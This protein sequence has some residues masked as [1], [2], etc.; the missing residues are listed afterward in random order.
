MPSVSRP[1]AVAIIAVVYILTGLAGLVS[2]LSQVRL[3]Q[4]FE[5]DVL[6]AALVAL[7]AIV[8]GIFLWRGRDWA[9]WLALAWIGFHVVL[10]FFHSAGEVVAHG[11]LFAVF[12]WFL[13]HPR[14]N[15]YFRSRRT[16]QS[17]STHQ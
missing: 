12:A 14:S 11:L 13:F 1:L 2:H 6:W 5:S 10:S 17:F 7:I 15:E 16:R 3:T 9:R 8:A 4:P